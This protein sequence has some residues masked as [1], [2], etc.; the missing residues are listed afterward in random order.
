MQSN[1]QSIID[2]YD[3]GNDGEFSTG[4]VEDI[5][6]DLK[7]IQ[8]CA[9]L[10][11][12]IILTT[13]LA[14]AVVSVVDRGIDRMQQKQVQTADHPSVRNLQVMTVFDDWIG[15]DGV[16]TVPADLFS[17]DTMSQ[18]SDEVFICR[19][20][21]DNYNCGP[22]STGTP[23]TSPPP[24]TSPTSSSPTTSPT[25]SPTTSSPTFSQVCFNSEGDFTFFGNQR[26]CLWLDI[27]NSPGQI[28]TI[29]GED[30]VATL[31]PAS[32]GIC[33]EDNPTFTTVTAF[34][35]VSCEFILRNNLKAQICDVG[36]DAAIEARTYCPIACQSCGE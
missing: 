1:S 23:T 6:N 12:K 28:E 5:V 34:G 21:I 32:C 20:T 22:D 24:T 14:V 31:C 19:P 25:A 17:P 11:R 16:A 26:S 18:D 9:L 33:C 13:C 30:G 7:S 15:C 27:N 8:R 10:K 4:E 3:I 29:C 2:K 36:D 35:P